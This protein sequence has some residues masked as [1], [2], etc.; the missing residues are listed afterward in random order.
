MHWSSRLTRHVIFK[1]QFTGWR[2]KPGNNDFGESVTIFF[3]IETAEYWHIINTPINESM[4][5]WSQL[6]KEMRLTGNGN[7][8]YQNQLL[9]KIDFKTILSFFHLLNNKLRS[10]LTSI[11]FNSFTALSEPFEDSGY[12]FKKKKKNTE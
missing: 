9:I 7:K 10:I 8:T 12:N 3:R 4:T 11:P 2:A 5:Q 6:S 1:L